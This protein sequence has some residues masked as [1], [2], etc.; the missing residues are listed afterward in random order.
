MVNKLVTTF[1]LQNPKKERKKADLAYSVSNDDSVWIGPELCNSLVL[2]EDTTTRDVA[3]RLCD[4]LV[5]KF[6]PGLEFQFHWSGFK[7]LQ[8]P[9]VS[10]EVGGQACEADLILLS[11][12]R[13][14]NLPLEV[15]S[16]LG[17]WL[18]R[19][20]TSEGAL[21]ILEASGPTPSSVGWQ[22]AHLQGLA[23]RTRLDYLSMV[24]PLTPEIVSDKLR[25]DQTMPDT[26]FLQSPT[27]QFHSSGWG[28]N[29]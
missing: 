22:Q 6:R 24:E 5:V 15:I 17:L 29:E 10:H 7:Y 13:L 12:G 8:V 19:R 28:I 1:P 27:H 21:V 2:Y 26:A 16:W 9:E 23:R 4:R 18:P 3:L 11:V 20:K 14:T 25:E